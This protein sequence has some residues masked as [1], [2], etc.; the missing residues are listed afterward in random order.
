MTA[1]LHKGEGWVGLKKGGARAWVFES[2]PVCVGWLCGTVVWATRV[3]GRPTEA[4]LGK[5]MEHVKDG[6]DPEIC[7]DRAW[8]QRLC[9]LFAAAAC[10]FGALV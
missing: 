6:D 5:P 10:A 1:P 8:H 7:D 2:K 9:P 4:A 3:A